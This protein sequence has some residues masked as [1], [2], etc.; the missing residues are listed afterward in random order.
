MPCDSFDQ[1]INQYTTFKHDV[2][3]PDKKESTADQ[4]NRKNELIDKRDGRRHIEH[5]SPDYVHR[6]VKPRRFD[7]TCHPGVHLRLQLQLVHERMKSEKHNKRKHVK[8]ECAA[9]NQAAYTRRH[10]RQEISDVT[11]FRKRQHQR[12]AGEKIPREQENRRIYPH[13]H[14]SGCKRA[15][16]CR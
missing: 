9:K 5:E 4:N 8:K 10:V 12:H 3:I 16:E 1:A 6:A 7:Q 2:I 14:Q 13:R 15:R 11:L